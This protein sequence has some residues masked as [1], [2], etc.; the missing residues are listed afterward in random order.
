MYKTKLDN[1]LESHWGYVSWGHKPQC[2]W[3]SMYIGNALASLLDWMMGLSDFLF[4]NRMTRPSICPVTLKSTSV[5][6]L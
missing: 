5:L 6:P 4:C 2:M 1:G 3:K